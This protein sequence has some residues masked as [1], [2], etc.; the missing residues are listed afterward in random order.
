VVNKGDS[1][2]SRQSSLN[3]SIECLS[4]SSARSSQTSLRTQGGSETGVFS[5]EYR[6]LMLGGPGVGKSSICCQFLSSEH[7]NTYA[8]VEDSV[9]KEVVVAVNGEESRVVFID[10]QHG[11]MKLENLVMTYEPHAFLVV[12]AVDDISSLAIAERLMAGLVSS[13]SLDGRATILVANKSDLVRTREV[14]TSVGKQLA[15]KYNVKYIET[16]PG[17]NHNIDEL[18]VGIVTQIR[19]KEAGKDGKR[20]RVDKVLLKGGQMLDQLLSRH[21]NLAKSCSNLSVV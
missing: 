3:S 12:L 9:E 7:V 16:S 17:I 14:K 18:L 8:R 20:S 13:S 2:R 1:F 19:L 10:H 11:T 5:P 15:V 21:G 6:V 4:Q